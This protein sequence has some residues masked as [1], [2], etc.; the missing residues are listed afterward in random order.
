MDLV[1]IYDQNEIKKC[2]QRLEKNLKTGSQK[3]GI[4]GITFRPSVRK[5]EIYWLKGREVWA[6]F[7]EGGNRFWNPFGVGDPSAGKDLLITVEINPPYRGIDRRVGGAFA[8]DP[9]SGSIYLVHRGNMGGGRTGVGKNTFFAEYPEPP[10]SIYDEGLGESPAVMV[11]MLDDPGLSE[12][13]T[14][15]VNTVER[16][17]QKLS[18]GQGPEPVTS[19]LPK[20]APEFEGL[21]KPYRTD[22]VIHSISNHGEVVNALVA[23]ISPY[24][25]CSN[26]KTADGNRPDI[27]FAFKDRRRGSALFEVK[28]D[29][30]PSSIYTGIGQ[31][32]YYAQLYKPNPKHLVAVFPDS[33]EPDRKRRLELIGIQVATFQ[34]NGKGIQFRG[35]QPLLG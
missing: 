20:F 13:V 34:K 35:L 10:V 8:R 26:V 30:C 6:A 15:F 29:T 28:T 23:Q 14:K 25:T 31:L 9:L 33:L 18:G 2:Q 5:E 1:T 24:G 22:A 27:L 19:P 3:M 32:Q 17:K 11:G 12:S 4:R 7:A 21:R 16:I